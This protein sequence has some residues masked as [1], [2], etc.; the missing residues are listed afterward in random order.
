MANTRGQL[1]SSGTGGPG[2]IK[3]AQI[4]AILSESNSMTVNYSDAGGSRTISIDSMFAS[5]NSGRR[6]MPENG[7]WVVLGFRS[8]DSTNPIVLRY[9][10][11]DEYNLLLR[12]G[13]VP[14]TE[15]TNSQY[16]KPTIQTGKGAPFRNLSPG[17]LEDFSSG[18]A[19]SFASAR[20][21]WEFWG[22]NVLMVL[23][24]D[25]LEVFFATPEFHIRGTMQDDLLMTDT[26]RWG[27]VSRNLGGNRTKTHVEYKGE[28]AKEFYYDLT[29]EGGVKNL[30]VSQEGICLD[31]QGADVTSG[32][33]GSP[34]RARK[35]YTTEAGD[36][37]KH[38]TD[39]NGNVI[40]EVSQSADKGIYLL[41]RGG[42]S[43]M[44]HEIGR[45]I[46]RKVGRHTT[47]EIGGNETAQVAGNRERT[48]GGTDTRSVS[49]NGLYTTG[50]TMTLKGSMIYIN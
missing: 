41:A 6:A 26:L 29:W 14:N 39:V 44:V 32:T 17:E 48:I 50:G 35:H 5:M 13:Q 10:S 40:V 11:D 9:M 47:D 31:A 21:R 16:S 18:N 24:R 43:N 20:G 45:D 12:G 4:T 46:Q 42:N 8:D 28:F 7:S 38:E 25:D 15:G 19:R 1:K 37:T 27:V 30:V 3:Y 34:L 23:D 49:G 36:L 22:G 33:T 2:T